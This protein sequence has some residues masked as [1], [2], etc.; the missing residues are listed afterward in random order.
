MYSGNRTDDTTHIETWRML[1]QIAATREFRYVADS[2]L[3][4]DE[5]LHYIVP[6]GGRAITIMP[7]TWAEV[8][9][10]EAA[11]RTTRKAK[12]EI[13]RRARPNHEDQTE[14]FSVFAGEHRTRKRGYR[15]HWIYSSEKRK[16]DRAARAQQLSRAGLALMTLNT[17]LNTR[18]LK[19]RDPIETA[20]TE[21]LEHHQVSR[22]LKVDIGTASIGRRVQVGKGRPGKSTHYELRLHTIYTFTWHRQPRP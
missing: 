20:V 1:C 19:A 16:R 10:F 3:C 18:H 14:Y 22:V 7:E 5:Q 6:H 17:K 13:W 8:A 2:K 4:T 12:K 21:S 9:A 11:L 15:L